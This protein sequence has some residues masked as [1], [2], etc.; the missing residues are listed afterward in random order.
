MG[1][2]Y[3]TSQ[4][5]QGAGLATAMRTD[6]ALAYEK[7]ILKNITITKDWFDLMVQNQWFEQPPLA[8]NRKKLAQDK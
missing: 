7:I 2:L 6:L 3:Q 4:T 8:P 1:F 5:F